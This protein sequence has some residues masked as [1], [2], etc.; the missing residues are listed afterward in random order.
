MLISR[1]KEE[2]F[3]EFQCSIRWRSDLPIQSQAVGH[4]GSNSSTTNTGWLTSQ[5]Y[6]FSPSDTNIS[7]S[8]K[9]F[10]FSLKV[11]EH[12][13]KLH[14]YLHGTLS[15]D[16]HIYGESIRQRRQSKR[17][18][19]QHIQATECLRSSSSSC[20]SLDLES[21]MASPQLPSTDWYYKKSLFTLTQSNCF[22]SS[23]P[24]PI[25]NQYWYASK[26]STGLH[27]N[28]IILN[29]LFA[30]LLCFGHS[31]NDILLV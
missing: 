7:L 17:F 3:K 26:I 5:K 31:S 1:W 14:H 18:L 11:Y 8:W 13:H 28:A 20:L 12:A 16:A 24:H 4:T 10:S 29:F 6:V 30:I 15:F 23:S 19:C 9:Y 2:R 25:G 22:H 27:L 21:D